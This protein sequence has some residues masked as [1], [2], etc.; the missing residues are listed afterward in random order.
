MSPSN[1]KLVSRRAV[2]AGAVWSVPVILTAV[3]APT[4]SASPIGPPDPPP[5]CIPGVSYA[6]VGIQLWNG[7]NLPQGIQIYNNTGR[8][9][10]V[11]GDVENTPDF[12]D[13]GNEDATVMLAHNGGSFSIDVPDGGSVI[14][15]IGVEYESNNSTGFM[16]LS[17]ACDGLGRFKMKTVHKID[18]L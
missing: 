8:V 7:Q 13:V 1:E 5:I 18:R 14:L 4:A 6:W 16:Q 17:S 12:V 3:A 15:R 11:N 10:A 9:I 2:N